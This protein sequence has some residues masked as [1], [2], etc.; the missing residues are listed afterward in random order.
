[1]HLIISYANFDD[2]PHFGML[3]ICPFGVELRKSILHL[4]FCLQ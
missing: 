3:Q 1:M 4:K 2:E